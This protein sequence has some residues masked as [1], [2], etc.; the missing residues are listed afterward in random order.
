MSN[1]GPYPDDR[2]DDK[3]AMIL[4]DAVMEDLNSELKIEEITKIGIT[5]DK[6]TKILHLFR[7]KANASMTRHL[8]MF[9]PGEKLRDWS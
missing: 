9:F 7:T 5:A 2:L 4:F 6:A 8:K 3:K 1:N